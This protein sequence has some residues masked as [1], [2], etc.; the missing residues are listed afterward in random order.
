MKKVWL[1]IIGII[2][3]LCVLLIWGFVGKIYTDTHPRTCDI[4]IKEKIN[5]GGIV[6]NDLPLQ[7][8]D[9]NTYLC[10]TWHKDIQLTQD[11]LNEQVKNK[12]D[13]LFGSSG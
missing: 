3:I 9:Y 11:Q 2:A 5:S 4:G 10:F 12:T 7:V 8:R 1:I 13:S 6:Y